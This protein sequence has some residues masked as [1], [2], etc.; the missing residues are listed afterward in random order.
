MALLTNAPKGTGDIL[1]KDFGI[2]NY[3]SD[4]CRDVSSIY[5]FGE[6]STPTFEHTE[7]F[8]RSVG[9]TTDVVQKEMYTFTDKGDRSITLRPEGTAGVVRAAIENGLLNEALPI[10]LHYF[11]NCFRYEKM[12]A[13]RLREFHQ[14]GVEVFGADM[15]A[16]DAEVIALAN[17]IIKNLGLKNI[18]LYINSIGCKHCRAQYQEALKN[19]YAEHLADICDTCKIRYERNPMRLLDCKVPSCAERSVTAPKILD[20]I[21][22]DCKNHFEQVKDYLDKFGI[23]YQIDPKIVRGLDYYCKTVFEFVSSDIG[24]QSTILGGGRYDGLIQDVGGPDVSGIGF[25]MGIERVILA[26]NAQGIKP[27]TDSPCALYI[28]SVGEKPAKTAAFMA[29]T[30]REAGFWVEFD[31]VGRSLKSQLKYADKIGAK[32]MMIIG[33][34]ELANNKAVLKNMSTGD[35]FDLV[36]NDKFMDILTT[37]MMEDLS[38]EEDLSELEF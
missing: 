36:I 22:D 29:M 25:A 5:G 28:A 9:A 11:S 17:N 4:T 14:F 30:L 31:I 19:Y 33:D 18:I 13:G 6:I 32:F 8:N 23:E 27:M 2:W 12:Q 21:C 15:P 3:V 16:A 24:S 1:P 38:V 34:D 10:K 35:K 37:I 7:L 26:L 20:Y